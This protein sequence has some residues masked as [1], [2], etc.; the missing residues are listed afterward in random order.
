MTFVIVT[1]GLAL[2]W[3][4][5]VQPP[6][7]SLPATIVALL[8]LSTVGGS[9]RAQSPATQPPACVAPETADSADVVLHLTVQTAEPE[10][11]SIAK[12]YTLPQPD[13]P[14]I[15]QA[16]AR[17]FQRPAALHLTVDER[18][19]LIPGPNGA[20]PEIA[21]SIAFVL[22]RD[23]RISRLRIHRASGAADIDTLLLAAVITAADS[24]DFSGLLME[25][26]ADALPLWVGVTPSATS[27]RVARLQLLRLRLPRYELE[28]VGLLKGQGAVRFPDAG[29]IPD[30]KDEILLS[31]VV[32]PD[33]RVLKDRTDVVSG[34]Y[35]EFMK[36][37]YDGLARSKFTP[38]KYHG[39][40]RSARVQRPYSFEVR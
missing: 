23:G 4:G 28:P 38:A 14:L 40:P 24:G 8:L 20:V 11:V 17:R 39:C 19:V 3:P 10:I 2:R 15:A 36:A 5:R 37:A 16:I 21:G 33:G 29:R 31:F 1:V 25:T 34:K 22:H 18:T 9:A 32:G 6:G 26:R 7:A 13:A 30:M 27:E 35:R 12:A